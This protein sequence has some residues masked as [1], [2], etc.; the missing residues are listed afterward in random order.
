MKRVGFKLWLL[1]CLMSLLFTCSVSAKSSNDKKLRKLAN[2]GRVAGPVGSNTTKYSINGSKS[3]KINLKKWGIDGSLKYFHGMFYRAKLKKNSSVKTIDNK[4]VKVKKGQEVI[5][6]YFPSRNGKTI[7]RLKNKQTVYI[8]AK[9]LKV[10]GYIYNSKAAYSDHQIEEYVKQ[11]GITSKTDYILFVSK[12]N[13][14]AWV[15]EKKKGAWVCKYVL[16]VSTGVY[17]QNDIPNDIYGINSC[18]INTHSKNNAGFDMGIS[19]AS[20]IG[21]NQIHI[22]TPYSPSTH[23]CIAMGKT[24]YNFVFW[25]LPVGTR[26]VLY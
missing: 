6:M 16:G 13:Q 14:H 4:K 2:Y 8:P 9:L 17:T 15:L 25:Y 26:V 5:I 11:R 19:Y 22:G 21:G 24:E 10:T 1:V 3:K 7:C 23:G 18:S 12:Y 20:S